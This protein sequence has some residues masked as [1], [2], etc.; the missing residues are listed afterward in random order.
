MP[1]ISNRV[2]AEVLKSRAPFATVSESCRRAW[3][4]AGAGQVGVLANGGPVFSAGGAPIRQ[5]ACLAGRGC[6][7]KGV[8]GGTRAGGRA[9]L[10]AGR[11][12]G[13]VAAR[14]RPA[15]WRHVLL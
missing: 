6:P 8:R 7:E 1:A 2:L 13:A 5:D 12:G 14:A 4:H 10:G 11:A 9:A 3:A 15:A